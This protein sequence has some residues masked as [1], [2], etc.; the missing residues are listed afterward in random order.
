MSK[1]SIADLSRDL[2]NAIAHLE[3]TDGLE[4]V[5]IVIRV[6]DGVAWIHGLKDA[7][8]NEVLEI[9]SESG[10]VEA[11][12]LNLNEDEMNFIKKFVLSSGSL[13]EMASYYG[14]TYPTVRQRLDNLI[15]KI[16]ENDEMSEDPYVNLIKRLAINDKLDFE[17]ANLLI[18]EYEKKQKP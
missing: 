3:A 14:V 8:Y 11:F 17:T 6:G 10:A 7:K 16:T 13:K 4:K 9:E 15:N 2:R 12:A 1:L 5:G 18:G